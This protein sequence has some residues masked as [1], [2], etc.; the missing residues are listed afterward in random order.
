MKLTTT[1]LLATLLVSSFQ[2]T[3]CSSIRYG[4][5]DKTETTT[6]DWGSKD[7]QQFADFMVGSLIESPGL[8]Y[9][10]SEGKGADKRIIVAFGG[11]A[12][13][14]SEHI[15]TE[16]ISRRIQDQLLESGKFRFVARK[17]AAGQDEIGDEIRFQQGSGRVK[18]EMAKAFGQQ[19]GADIV[20][21]GALA[22]ISKS[23]GRSVESVGTKKKDVYY[24]FY[25]SAVN[26][27]TGE[28]LWGK[29]E[30]IRKEA[31][32]GLFGRG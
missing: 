29:T 8:N 4:D 15:N 31:T 25:M 7:L 9:M 14:T 22:D 3:G 30:D 12:N 2:A 18:P 13:E 26:I 6:I 10:D 21:Y 17:E 23:T 27:T 11:I 32:V 20:L 19:L 24:Q 5:P 28:I 1:A 16:M